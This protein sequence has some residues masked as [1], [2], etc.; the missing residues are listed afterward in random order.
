MGRAVLGQIVVIEGEPNGRRKPDSLARL[1][2]AARKLFVERGYDATRPQDIAREAGLGHGTFYLH[3]P[4][5]RACFLRFVDDARQEL[6]EQMHVR[7]M[8]GAGLEQRVAAMVGAIHEYA[9]RHPGVL[10]AAMT[11]GRVIDA[12]GVEAKSLLKL[13]GTDWADA[14]RDAGKKDDTGFDADMIG[15]AVAGA[16]YQA[17]REIHHSGRSREELTK[18]LTRFLTRALRPD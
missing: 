6:D 12:D 8:P 1:K 17:S 15:Q 5:K 11:D 3:F 18:T 16:L 9:E 4:D 10:R 14:L 7:L 2:Q 13:W